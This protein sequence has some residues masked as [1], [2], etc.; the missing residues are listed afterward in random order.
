[1]EV[2]Q[3]INITPH[4]PKSPEFIPPSAT[5]TG[6]DDILPFGKAE[7]PRAYSGRVLPNPGGRENNMIR[8]REYRKGERSRRRQTENP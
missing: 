7:K 3:T 2:L 4:H 6:Q 1:M 5:Q 8:D